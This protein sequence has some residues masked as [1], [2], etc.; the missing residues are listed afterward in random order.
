MHVLSLSPH[1]ALGGGDSHTSNDVDMVPVTLLS[2]AIV[3]HLACSLG[4][5]WAVQEKPLTVLLFC[6]SVCQCILDSIDP[7]L[8][9]LFEILV[10]SSLHSQ[11]LV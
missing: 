1:L 3:D 10:I 11:F 8:C 9:A 4:L 6:D 5:C 7:S 2:N